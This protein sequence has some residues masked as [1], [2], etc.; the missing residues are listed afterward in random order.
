MFFLL[1]KL[2]EARYEVKTRA[3]AHGAS[4]SFGTGVEH[5]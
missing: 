3:G 5:I 1:I 4:L 2:I